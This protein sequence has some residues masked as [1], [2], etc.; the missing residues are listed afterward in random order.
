MLARHRQ[1][2]QPSRRSSGRSRN[3]A[4]VGSTISRKNSTAPSPS[5][6]ASSMLGAS[7]LICFSG[8]LP[9]DVSRLSRSDTTPSQEK[10][11][12]TPT[13]HRI[14]IYRATISR[15]P[16]ETTPSARGADR[17]PGRLASCVTIIMQVRQLRA[18]RASAPMG[19]GLSGLSR[20][21]R[22]RSGRCRLPGI[23]RG[24]NALPPQP[25]CPAPA[26]LQFR[27]RG[28]P[29]NW[30]GLGRLQPVASYCRL[31]AKTGR[32]AQLETNKLVV[33]TYPLIIADRRLRCCP[34]ESTRKGSENQC[35]HASWQPPRPHQRIPKR[36]GQHGPKL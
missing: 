26:R 15:S 32:R 4:T 23:G 35:R 34:R 13:A 6:K 29:P 14:A 1:A 7:S 10:P 2:K 5:L 22:T 17:A 36:V 8:W 9:G 3:S 33:M 24:R 25:A 19:S 31:C 16:V 20:W 28:R 21:S 12:T 30:L 11:Q 18:G 27:A